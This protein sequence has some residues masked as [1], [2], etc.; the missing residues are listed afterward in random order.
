MSSRQS[1]EPE[2]S[3]L[4]AENLTHQNLPSLSY[5][6]D[7][8]TTTV[9]WHDI[10]FTGKLE[11]WC[12]FEE[13][14][15][16]FCRSIDWKRHETPLECNFQNDKLNALRFEEYRCGE[17]ISVNGRFAQHALQVNSVVGKELGYSTT[18]GD[19]RACTE[20]KTAS[21]FFSPRP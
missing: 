20:N 5:Q 6:N 18:F 14:V 4:T 3:F 1:S 15:L 10:H 13:E 17:E 2:V 21:D 11:S 16:D 7:H 9:A 8:R 19:W 12:G